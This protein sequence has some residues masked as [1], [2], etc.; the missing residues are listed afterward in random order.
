[1]LELA[2]IFYDAT[3]VIGQ[4]IIQFDIPQLRL[5]GIELHPESMIWDTMLMQHL[6]FPDLPHDLEF[7]VS[8]FLTKPAWKHEKASKELYAARDVDGTHQSFGPL[9]QELERTGLLDFYRDVQIP[10][11]RICR[12]MTETG[13]KI[14]PDRL[15]YVQEGTE[16]EIEEL[17][18]KL[19]SIC[20]R[21]S[22]RSKTNSILHRK[23]TSIRSPKDRARRSSDKCRR[24][25]FLGV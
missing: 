25:W 6:R 17:E 23:V 22:S 2:R 12:M 1:M 19:P 24:R 7:I 11:A 10:L 5:H 14:D 21:T 3:E 13:I 4:N 8:Q 18:L 9:L 15:Q 16:K 20:V